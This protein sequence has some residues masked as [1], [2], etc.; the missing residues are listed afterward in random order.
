MIEALRSAFEDV[1][2]RLGVDGIFISKRLKTSKVIRLICRYPES[3]YESGSSEIIGQVAEITIKN[4]DIIP[5][6]GDLIQFKNQ[7]Y[8]IHEEPLLDSSNI[9]YKFSAVLI[10]K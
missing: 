9:I 7:T 1:F 8:K 3:V 4:I 5:G 10:E 2:D 6:M